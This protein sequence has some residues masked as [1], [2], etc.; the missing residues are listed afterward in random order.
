MDSKNSNFIT[1]GKYN[2]IHVVI[3]SWQSVIEIFQ[4]KTLNIKD[5]VVMSSAGFNKDMDS[6]LLSIRSLLIKQN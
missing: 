4:Q 5:K 1:L 6:T 3:C 2:L